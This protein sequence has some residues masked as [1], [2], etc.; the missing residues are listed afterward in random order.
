MDRLAKRLANRA[1][2]PE[3]RR[4]IKSII[5]W[6]LNDENIFIDPENTYLGL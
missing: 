2:E 1:V 3:I 5:D 6:G 4:S